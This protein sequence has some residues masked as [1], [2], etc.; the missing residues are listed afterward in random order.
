MV[1]GHRSTIRFQ[2]HERLVAWGHFHFLGP[3]TRVAGLGASSAMNN[4]HLMEHV[5]K[6][7]AIGYQA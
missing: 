1:I 2:Q 7:T 5:P 6:V 3:Q 4:A